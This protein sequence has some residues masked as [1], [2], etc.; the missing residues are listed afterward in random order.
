[1]R[2]DIAP[3]PCRKG[4][5]SIIDHAAHDPACLSVG[6]REVDLISIS[7]CTELDSFTFSQRP[8]VLEVHSGEQFVGLREIV[9]CSS[10]LITPKE[11]DD[12]VEVFASRGAHATCGSWRSRELLSNR[13]DIAALQ[14][15]E[16]VTN[17]VGINDSWKSKKF[18]LACLK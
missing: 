5:G 15:R 13:P 12:A 6:N 17:S 1:M 8:C 9:E 16:P 18:A 2:P 4:Q 3:D 14:C 7:P 11:R 10:V